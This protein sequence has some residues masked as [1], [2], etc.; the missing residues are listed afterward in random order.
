MR[1]LKFNEMQEQFDFYNST[2]IAEDKAVIGA[3]YVRE[4][5]EKSLILLNL[6]ETEFKDR[7]T[8]SGSSVYWL[9]PFMI[10]LPLSQVQILSDVMGKENFKYVKIP[11]W[12]FKKN[13]GLDIK[14]IKGK[15]IMS[16]TK[17]QINKSFVDKLED[18]NVQ[19]Y[20]NITASS[21]YEKKEYQII[22]NT[23]KKH[24]NYEN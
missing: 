8:L 3:Y 6:Q 14:R 2:Y 22:L 17:N 13:P 5:Y 12:L 10:R 7:M 18:I 23:I 15:K 20:F 1:L 4:I 9:S 21:E 24:L 16:F 19:E 11:Y